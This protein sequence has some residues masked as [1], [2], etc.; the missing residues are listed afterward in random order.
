MAEI[1]AEVQARLAYLIKEYQA[2]ISVSA[3]TA[4]PRAMGYFPSVEEVWTNYV[5]NAIKYGGQP[6]YLTLPSRQVILKMKI[7]TRSQTEFGNELNWTENCHSKKS[8][9]RRLRR[10]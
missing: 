5:S 10:G 9:S 1:V 7:K 8:R 6:L 4:W 3:D 2:E